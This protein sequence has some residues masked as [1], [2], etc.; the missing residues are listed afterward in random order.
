LPSSQQAGI[1]FY[2]FLSF[3]FSLGW[4][5]WLIAASQGGPLG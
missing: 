2:E 4:A 1:T 3:G 5:A